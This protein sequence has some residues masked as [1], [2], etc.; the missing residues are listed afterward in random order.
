MRN[1]PFKI[2]KSDNLFDAEIED[3]IRFRFGNKK[4]SKPIPR[5]LVQRKLIRHKLWTDIKNDLKIAE[6]L[7]E[8][9]GF[10]IAFNWF[11][12]IVISFLAIV[13]FAGLMYAMGLINDVLNQTGA[14]NEINA[15]KPGYTNLTLAAQNTFGKANEAT[16]GLRLVA[17][18]LIFSLF[19]A[20]ILINFAIKI[21]PAYFFVYI[22]IVMLAIILSAPVSNAYQD[23][24][25]SG[26]YNGLLPSFTGANYFMI[27]LPIFIAIGGVL[28]GVFL[29]I[30]I[31]RGPG[32][33]GI[34]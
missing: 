4:D 8:E 28:G 21:H 31:L 11:N 18:T 22:L 3:I 6:F 1:H 16:Q 19:L 26:I 24:L 7:P 30:N 13:L 25:S 33:G 9:K 20:T 29:F 17:L 15:G 23:L 34:R 5:R 12:I 32:E 14:M 27:N 2:T 10:I